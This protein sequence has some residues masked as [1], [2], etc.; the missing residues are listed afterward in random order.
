MKSSAIRR[1]HTR[2]ARG[3]RIVKWKGQ[4]A[5]VAPSLFLVSASVVAL[6][7]GT[8]QSQVISAT[9]NTRAVVSA[10]VDTTITATGAVNLTTSGGP[11]VLIDTDYSSTAINNGTISGPSSASATGIGVLLDGD[12]SATGEII[13]NGTIAINAGSSTGPVAHY[14]HVAGHRYGTYGSSR[15]RARSGRPCRCRHPLSDRS[16]ELALCRLRCDRAGDLV[17]R[18]HHP[19]R[20]LGKG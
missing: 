5:S 20:F 7:V 8:A 4:V 15:S 3:G 1:P 2:V 19:G 18:C 13:N 11:A 12:L 16:H 6:S 14:D 9:Q 10:D 17:R